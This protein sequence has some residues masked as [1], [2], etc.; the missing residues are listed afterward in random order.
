MNADWTDPRRLVSCAHLLTEL[1]PDKRGAGECRGP[2]HRRRITHWTTSPTAWP[3]CTG[4]PVGESGRP[5]DRERHRDHGTG[6]HRVV[7]CGHEWIGLSLDAGH[8]AVDRLTA[9]CVPI[10]KVTAI[11]CPARG[12]HAHRAVRPR[13]A[14]RTDHVEVTTEAGELRGTRDR[15]VAMGLK[16]LE[17]A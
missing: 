11:V 9:A 17:S 8:L 16:E 13:L 5:D 1:L 14:A 7:Y 15:L 3:N 12:R 10:V 6:D 4:P 2:C